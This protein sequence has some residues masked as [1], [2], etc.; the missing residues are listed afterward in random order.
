MAKRITLDEVAINEP[1]HRDLRCLQMQVTIS[2]FL[3]SLLLWL[4][5]VGIVQ[6]EKI[7]REKSIAFHCIE[8][9]V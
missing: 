6:R 8:A 7:V 2:V 3:F 9:S 1:P 4:T 5:Y